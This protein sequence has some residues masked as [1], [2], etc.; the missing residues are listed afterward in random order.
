MHY[1][2]SNFNLMNSNSYWDKLKNNHTVIDKNYNGLII[3]LNKKNLDNYIFFHSILYID[4]FNLNQTIKEL[5]N[6]IQIVKK[7]KKKYFFLYLFNNFYKNPIQEKILND[8][9]FKIK[10]DLENLI[11]KIFNHNS[12]LFSDRN[13]IYIRFPFELKFIKLISNE[14]KKNIIFFSYKPY[15]LIILDC[16]NTLWGG[17]LDEDGDENINY[18]G[19]GDGQLFHQFQLFLKEKKK[20]GFVLTISSKNN[21]KK[22]WEVMKKRGMILQKKY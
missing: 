3:S 6:F 16:D 14:I 20:Q 10:F 4:A 7:L 19:D 5:K 9:L 15:K 17:I 12:K 13:R 8:Y 1:L 11:V 22:V 18:G 21:E 2:T